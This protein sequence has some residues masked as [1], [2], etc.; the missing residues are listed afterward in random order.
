MNSDVIIYTSGLGVQATM[1]TKDEDIY[2]INS[3]IPISLTEQLEVGGFSGKFISF[4]SY[5]EI[6]I[7]NNSFAKVAI[8]PI[9]AGKYSLSASVI[10]PCSITF[11][12][13]L[14]FI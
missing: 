14:N 7:E 2:T 13:L 1:H 9:I 12:L 6:G 5:F 10:S 4:G 11:A 8:P 3:F